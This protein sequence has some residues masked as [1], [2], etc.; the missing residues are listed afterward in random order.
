MLFEPIN[1]AG[2]EVPNRFVRSATH[3]WMAESDGTPT[4]RIGDLYEELARN[5]VGLIITGYAYVN[6][7]GKSD[8]LQQG[9]YDD[10]FIQSYK[11]IVA[12]VHQHSSKIVI[13]IAHGGRQTMITAQNPYMLAPSAIVDTTKGITPE[14]MTEKEVL[15]TIEDFRRL[16]EGQKKL[17]LMVYSCIVHTVFCSAILYL[18]ILTDERIDGAVP[19]KKGHRWSLT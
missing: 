17:D 7:K 4:S 18:R 10:R 9:I 14:E 8:H 5:E 6:P 13:Q 19:L 12:R 16:Q 3:E 1:I 2:I 15:E 11:K